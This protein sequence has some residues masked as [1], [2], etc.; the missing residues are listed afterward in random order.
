M[1]VI[2]SHCMETSSESQG[3]KLMPTLFD[4]FVQSAIV[5]LNWSAKLIKS[6]NNA[7]SLVPLKSLVILAPTVPSMRLV[8]QKLAHVLAY[9]ITTYFFLS[10][11]KD[12]FF[13]A[14][15]R[16]RGII[17]IHL[18]QCESSML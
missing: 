1:C 17:S 14:Q 2:N 15:Y 3:Q 13:L 12:L 5:M 11:H 8:F 6:N 7:V 9:I 18:A 16:K 10:F 4:N